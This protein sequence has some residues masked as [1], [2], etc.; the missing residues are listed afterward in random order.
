LTED[1]VRAL[2]IA[3]LVAAAF[4]A[5]PALAAGAA[6]KSEASASAQARGAQQKQPKGYYKLSDGSFVR[7]YATNNKFFAQ[8]DNGMRDELVAVTQNTWVAKSSNVKLMF[9]DLPDGREYD[10]VMLA[11]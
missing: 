3:S 2:F 11:M 8:F 4:L 10:V 7:I 9:Q 1:I 5:A 6:G